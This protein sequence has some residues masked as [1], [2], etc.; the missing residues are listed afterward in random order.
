MLDKKYEVSLNLKGILTMTKKIKIMPIVLI[1]ISI[2]M[3]YDLAKLVQNDSKL[4]ENYTFRQLCQEWNAHPDKRADIATELAKKS[5]LK[6]LS[7]QEVTNLL[8]KSSKENIKNSIFLYGCKKEK[9][10]LFFE[11]TVILEIEFDKNDKVLSYKTFII[12]N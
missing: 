3:I 8:E 11:Y 2:F 4:Y 5:D 12:D 6:G 9:H 7:K 10:L 1:L